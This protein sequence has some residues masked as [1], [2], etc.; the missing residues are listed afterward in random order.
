MMQHN[1][2]FRI[3]ALTATPGGKPEAVQEIVDALHISHIEIRSES[4]ADLKKYLHTKHE[5]EHIVPMTEDIAVLRDALAAVITVGV[6]RNECGFDRA[7]NIM[8][9]HPQESTERRLPQ[10][11]ERHSN[12]VTPLQVSVYCGGNVKESSPELRNFRCCSAWAADKSHGLSGASTQAFSLCG[13]C[14]LI[15]CADGEQYR[16]VLRLP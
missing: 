9:A 1:P 13:M 11:W 14:D 15:V 6:Q 10:E 4:D 3:L 5:Q 12:N 7:Q 16:H 2:H 8:T